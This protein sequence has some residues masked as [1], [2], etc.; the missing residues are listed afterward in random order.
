M[1]NKEML[2]EA[3]E[4]AAEFIN[5]NG[6]SNFISTIQAILS[7]AKHSCKNEY[8]QKQKFYKLLYSLK[9]SFQM[10]IMSGGKEIKNGFRQFLDQYL[11]LK[12]EKEYIVENEDFKDCSMEEIEYILG[13]TRRL[14]KDDRVSPQ[15]TYSK[16]IKS[17]PQKGKLKNKEEAIGSPIK[18]AFKGL[19]L[20]F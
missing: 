17:Y 16:N 9:N 19:N 11:K 2:L 20:D 14:I 7:V 12:K 5:K 18:N 4:R 1:N 8:E 6:Y 10:E 3:A 13:W 15:N